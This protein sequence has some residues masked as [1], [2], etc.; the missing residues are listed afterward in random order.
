MLQEII[1]RTERAL[2]RLD[3]ETERI[4]ELHDLERDAPARLA[5]LPVQIEAVEDRLDTTEATMTELRTY[6]ESVWGPVRGNLEEAIADLVER[7]WMRKWR[8]SGAEVYGLERAA[9]PQIRA[10][11]RK[12][13]AREDG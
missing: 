6:R 3:A 12:H 2:A 8:V 10:W 7:G 1:Q 5:A 9:L 13:P 4:R 11:V